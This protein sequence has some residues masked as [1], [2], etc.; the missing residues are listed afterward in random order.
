VTTEPDS[1]F[2]Q[3]E[4]ASTG[5]ATSSAIKTETIIVKRKVSF[6][7]AKLGGE[8]DAMKDPR[9]RSLAFKRLSTYALSYPYEMERRFEIHS[10]PSNMILAFSTILR[11]I[12]LPL[13]VAS[14]NLEAADKPTPNKKRR[15]TRRTR[16]TRH[17]RWNAMQ[18]TFDKYLTLVSGILRQY[19]IH[20]HELSQIR[21][22]K[23][24]AIIITDEISPEG[25]KGLLSDLSDWLRKIES[26]WKEIMESQP[27]GEEPLQEVDYWLHH[28]AMLSAASEAMKC[29]IPPHLKQTL[30][31]SGELMNE[32]YDFEK[33]VEAFLNHFHYISNE[34]TKEMNQS[35]DTLKIMEALNSYFKDLATNKP[36]RQLSGTIMSLFIG[37]LSLWDISYFYGRDANMLA[38]FE[39]LIRMLALRIAR[40]LN[41]ES[42]FEYK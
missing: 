33:N 23:E 6:V 36:I 25:L 19:N 17:A 13:L 38:L 39:R 24:L 1:V 16:G 5:P 42:L 9:S 10:V 14:G 29:S 27:Q 20:Q 4:T 40:E 31:K 28:I 30:I 11:S 35:R 2:E 26:F 41:L 12:Y 21:F 7:S 8:P 15:D 32:D 22:D 3:I 37:F 18:N 34:I